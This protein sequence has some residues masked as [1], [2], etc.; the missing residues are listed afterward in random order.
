MEPRKQRS[1]LQR[2]PRFSKAPSPYEDLLSP[3][4]EELAFDI[5]PEQDLSI[6]VSGAPWNPDDIRISTKPFSLRHIV[7]MISDAELD[8]AP[9]FQRSTIWKS[10]Q[11]S[12]LVE[13]ILLRIPLPAFY[14]NEMGDGSMQVV[15]GVQRLSAVYEFAR[16][17]LP[18]APKD[19]SRLLLEGMQYLA[20]LEDKG[21]KDL[22]PILRRRFDNTQIFANI[23]DP[24]TP[25][26]VKFD[27]FRRINTGGSPLNSQEIRHC[28]SRKSSRDFLKRCASSEHLTRSTDAVLRDNARMVDR[29][30]ALRFF[31]FRQVDWH[32]IYVK[33]RSLDEFL[34]AMTRRIE[35]M[36]TSQQDA[37]FADFDRAM[38]RAWRVFD[39]NAFRKWP[40]DKKRGPLNRSLFE[41]WSVALAECSDENALWKAKN[42]IVED[43]RRRMAKDE[44]YINSFTIATSDFRR[45]DTR[46]RVA[47]TIVEWAVQ[48]ARS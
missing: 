45:I 32:D 7:D 23:I 40:E 8:L 42:I 16:G 37:A 4:Q 18:Q 21:Y 24:Q 28:I 46:F 9:D 44:E 27:I 30:L 43:T 3:A 33:K 39:G 41:S 19:T 12:R 6:P 2:T 14:F 15:D 20:G 26:A 11:K 29:E 35:A 22:S 31:A 5:E 38:F 10:P 47:R 25:D 48:K 17:P 36:S 1:R 34:L 13:S